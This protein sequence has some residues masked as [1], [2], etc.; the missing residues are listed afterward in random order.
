MTKPPLQE[1]GLSRITSD[2]FP[3]PYQLPITILDARDE[4]FW[5]WSTLNPILNLTFNIL[6]LLFVILSL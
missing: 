6:L 4:T 1:G 5:E 2:L 3:N